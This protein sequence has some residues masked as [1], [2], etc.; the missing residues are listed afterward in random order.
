MSNHITGPDYDLY[1]EEQKEFERAEMAA[2]LEDA[3]EENN[4]EWNKRRWWHEAGPPPPYCPIP[5]EAG[6]PLIPLHLSE[7]HTVTLTVTVYD[8]SL[9]LKPEDLS[10]T[11][12]AIAR[13]EEDVRAYLGQFM[14][15]ADVGVVG[16]KVTTPEESAQ[17]RAAFPQE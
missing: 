4:Y 7:A 8:E 14:C 12:A 5:E 3:A 16:Y 13:L 6:P 17:L 11:D 10:P 9:D 2:D 1:E 15:V